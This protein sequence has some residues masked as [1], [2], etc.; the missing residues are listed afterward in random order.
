MQTERL[1]ARNVKCN[2]CVATIRKNLLVLPGVETV[3][4]T[5]APV[6]PQQDVSNTATGI[7]A[8]G[9]KIPQ[10]SIVEV[11]GTELSRDAIAIRLAEIGYP[12]VG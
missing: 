6:S 11:R 10:G 12:V 8:A 1:I 2:G 9:E 7:K 4:I 5:I 3:E